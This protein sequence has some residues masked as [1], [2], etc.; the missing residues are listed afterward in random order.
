MSEDKDTERD[1][2]DA[3]AEPAIPDAG[4]ILKQVA[5]LQAQAEQTLNN[6]GTTGEAMRRHNARHGIAAIGRLI[7]KENGHETGAEIVKKKKKKKMR[8]RL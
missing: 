1:R 6:L 8:V 5:A 2:D 7:R 3:V 4:A